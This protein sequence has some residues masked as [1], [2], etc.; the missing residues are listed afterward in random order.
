MTKERLMA[1]LFDVEDVSLNALELLISR[2]RKKLS[3]A[4]VDIVTVRGV[5]LP[6]AAR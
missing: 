4:S 3:G 5:G 1:Q 2:L 6:G